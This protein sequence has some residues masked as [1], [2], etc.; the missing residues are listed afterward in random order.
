MKNRV[1]SEQMRGL[2]L[3]EGTLRF[4]R[5]LERP[6]PGAGE[7]LIRVRL[8]GI[9]QTDL[10]L[11]KGYYPFQGILGHEFVGEVVAAPD[12]PK[13]LGKRVVGE[14][15]VVCHSCVECSQGRPSHCRNR[16]VLGIVNRQGCFA[17]YTILPTENLHTLPDEVSDRRA[18]F[19]EPLAAAL[20]I[21]QQVAISS[22][23]RVLLIGSGKLGQLIA[24]V[25]TLTGCSTSAVCR[26]PGQRMFLEGLE[27]D[28]LSEDQLALQQFDIVIDASGT[29]AGIEQAFQAVRPAG[30]IV[31]KSTYKGEARLNLSDMVVNEVRLVGS[32][33]GP[34]QEALRILK[35]EEIDP[36][37]LIEETVPL[38]EGLD[39]FEKA[40]RPGT[41]KILLQTS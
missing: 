30:T 21:P 31:M 1:S 40:E 27:I 24:R 29:A 4:S 35:E 16:T 38:N 14:I 12:Q 5:E 11:V 33:C 6:T 17:E 19:A 9:C 13:W 36:Q 41:M 23:D 25:L 26:H 32:R 8:A 34:F 22:S 20:Q 39:A 3:E 15:N 18:V 28:L 7:A 10:E 2:W 37:P